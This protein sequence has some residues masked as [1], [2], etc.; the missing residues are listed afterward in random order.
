MLEIFGMKRNKKTNKILSL[1]ICK[2]PEEKYKEF[3]SI[4]SAR[5]FRVD[6]TFEDYI[7][8]V[9]QDCYWCGLPVKGA[10]LGLSRLDPNKPFTKINTIPC[11]LACK[12]LGVDNSIFT[13]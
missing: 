7:K 3:V 9:K 13:D 8:I 6:I 2:T 4:S 10:G 12:C 11:C 5:G 1:Y